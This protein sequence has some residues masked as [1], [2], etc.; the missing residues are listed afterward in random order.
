[1]VTLAEIL[2]VLDGRGK[3]EAEPTATVEKLAS[4]ENAG[5]NDIS[6]LSSPK[7]RRTLAASRVGYVLIKAEMREHCPESARVIEVDDPYWAFAKVSQLFETAPKREAGIHPTAQIAA[8]AQ[9][10]ASAY[11]GPGVVIEDNV[12][13]G[14]EAYIGPLSVIHEGVS[15]GAKTRIESR[16]VVHHQC[17][18]GEQCRLLSGAVIGGAGFGFAP[19]PG[20]WERIAQIGRV[21]IGDRVEIGANTTIDRGAIDDT[22]I[23]DDVII[24]NLIQIGHN[25]RLGARS[26]MAGQSG[27]A[28]SA[29]IG[30]DCTIGGQAAIAGHIEIADGS[31]FTGQAMV[32]KGTKEAGVYSSGIPAQKAQ[33]WRKMVARI[34]QLEKLMAR[35]DALEDATQ[36]DKS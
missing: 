8:S 35:V 23:E 18:I 15:I 31:F 1:M 7:H 16:V 21:V 36:K 19:K 32:T 34:R 20:G 5:P 22:V 24:D 10:D 2:A 14:A 11:I 3:T 4:L 25:V 6:F 30:K 29:T 13:V 17:V 33:D 26:A 28:G 9:V 27:I 12:S